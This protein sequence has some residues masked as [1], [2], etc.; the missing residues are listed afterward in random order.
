MLQLLTFDSIQQE[1]FFPLIFTLACLL[2]S[3]EVFIVSYQLSPFFPFHIPY[4]LP[5]LLDCGLLSGGGAYSVSMI[6][7]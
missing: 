4:F 6:R 1:H 3:C 7:T 5:H 2:S